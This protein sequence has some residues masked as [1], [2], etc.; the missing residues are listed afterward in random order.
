MSLAR[1]YQFK[2]VLEE[3]VEILFKETVHNIEELA[4]KFLCAK[5]SVQ[6]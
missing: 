6:K 4:L 3:S 2:M 1:F 5:H